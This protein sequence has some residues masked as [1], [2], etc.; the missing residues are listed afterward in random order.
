MWTGR[1][2]YE[3]YAEGGDGLCLEKTLLK[4]EQWDGKRQVKSCKKGNSG[5]I[6]GAILHHGHDWLLQQLQN[7]LRDSQN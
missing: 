6:W 7:L 4:G 2:D 3:A 1:L 5:W